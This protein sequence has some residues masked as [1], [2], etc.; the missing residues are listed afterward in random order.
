MFA[1]VARRYDFLNHLLSAG[2]DHRWRSRAARACG[3]G[4]TALDV[5]CGTG[6]LA[7]ALLRRG[8]WGCVVACDFSPPMLARARAKLAGA[9][10]AGRAAVL[11]ADALRLPLADASVDASASAF[12]LRNIEDPTRGLAEMVRVVRP[13]GRVVILEFHAPEGR[14][15]RAAA[16][17]LYFRRVLPTLGRWMA[18]SDLGG[19]RYLVDSVEA[20]GPPEATAAGMR[21]AGLREVT[22]ERLPGG[23]AAVLVGRKPR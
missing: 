17:G 16:F 19:Y 1:A 22:T 7:A 14:G 20:F 13:G 6:D 2:L 10:R 9:L 18:G 4:E 21:A 23:I 8:G 5:C 15:L 11:E 3:C 12:G